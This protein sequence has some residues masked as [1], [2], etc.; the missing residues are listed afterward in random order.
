MIGNSLFP[1]IVTI[2]FLLLAG[3]WANGQHFEPH[4]Y[5]FSTTDGLPSSQIYE[6]IQ[7]KNNDIWFGT[8]GGVVRYDGYEF[9]VFTVNEG[10][11][12]N[13]VFYLD[14]APDGR[15]WFYD[16]DRNLGYF[17]AQT[18]HLFR[19]NHL[20]Q[21]LSL[22]D[23]K[24]PYSI[25]VNHQR[26]SV[27]SG[28]RRSQSRRVIFEVSKTGE[29][30]FEK[31]FKDSNIVEIRRSSHNRPH[32]SSNL[33]VSK[34]VNLYLDDEFI[35]TIKV[36]NNIAH[37]LRC[38]Q[39]E[40]KIFFNV[41]KELFLLENKCTK[42]IGNFSEQI[43]ELEHRENGDLLVGTWS[44]LWVLPK[45]DFNSRYQWL[46]GKLISSI[47]EDNE[48]GLWIGTIYSG[49]YYLPPYHS[50]Q[51]VDPEIGTVTDLLVVNNRQCFAN[52]ERSIFF[53]NG[54]KISSVNLI[55]KTQGI[56]SFS[57][58]KNEKL[59][60]GGMVDEIWMIDPT[61]SKMEHVLIEDKWRYSSSMCSHNGALFGVYK[62][63]ID[64]W[65]VQNGFVFSGLDSIHSPKNFFH[66]IDSL[67]ENQILLG[68]KN[69][70][71][72]LESNKLKSYRHDLKFMKTPIHDQLILHD[73]LQIFAS[74][75]SGVLVLINQ[76][77]FLFTKENGLVDNDIQHLGR[78]KD[79]FVACSKKGLS[80]IKADGT[81]TNVTE[82]T[83]ITGNQINDM[84]C[85]QDTIWLATT[86]GVEYIVFDE[87]NDY[88]SNLQVKTFFLDDQELSVSD[89]FF[90]EHTENEFR[91]ELKVFS[92][93]QKGKVQYRYELRGYDND[94]RYSKNRDVHYS[95]LPSG[96]YEFYASYRQPNGYW[97]PEKLLFTIEKEQ[98]WWFSLWF[99]LLTT[100]ALVSL[101]VVIIYWRN[102]RFKKKTLEKYKLLDLERKALQSQLNPHFI[103][104]AMMSIQNL[105]EQGKRKESSDYLVK[106]SHLTR[107]A[108]NHS[109]K[110]YVP[111]KEEMD[112]IVNYVDLERLRFDEAFEFS[113]IVPP[114]LTDVLVPPTVI[115]PF[116]ENAI[117]HGLMPKKEGGRRLTIELSQRDDETLLC[118]IEDNGVGLNFHKKS[119]HQGP[120]HGVRLI[121]E[122]LQILL[123][124]NIHAVA[125]TNKEGTLE[126]G[127]LVTIIIPFLTHENPN[128]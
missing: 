28:T 112:L 114:V 109:T 121:E 58:W 119:T 115:Q 57:N 32:I 88:S 73:S 86:H 122:R 4:F 87:V 37:V 8:D 103:F 49:L 15:I 10:L 26:I 128:Y 29:F 3:E 62:N 84:A 99:I 61:D 65:E 36:D 51:S 21:D 66:C 110:M 81:I 40:D 75:N 56:Y 34:E 5:H 30:H 44:G 38:T 22:Q 20:L 111:L 98:P 94:W 85:H 54:N 16:I 92:P 106:F 124:P 6:I 78:G 46:E 48:G 25:E 63:F 79:Y 69:G 80:I 101:I 120:S 11:S 116:I 18:I 125:I 89:H 13:V 126:T 9:D 42:R 17:D 93:T 27:Y 47:C 7:A 31:E 50:N 52:K 2:A 100:T 14:E 77:P 19:Y 95:N 70:S 105:V 12:S 118:R 76:I 33:P 23:L 45:G 113:T 67:N 39:H 96:T 59:S 107:L 1:R 68:S 35:E 123:D 127:V 117:L 41:D 104:N 43:L 82:N 60:V 97:L 72:I 91:F 53:K 64:I 102:Q 24:R 55:N 71:F 74:L 90:I 108:L 83:G